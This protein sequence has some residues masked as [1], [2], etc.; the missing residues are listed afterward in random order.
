MHARAVGLL[1]SSS[2]QRGSLEVAS[3]CTGRPADG[4]G[5]GGSFKL[6]LREHALAV[7]A[8]RRGTPEGSSCSCGRM[9]C[10]CLHEIAHRLPTS[11][12]SLCAPWWACVQR[13]RR[14]EEEGRP[15]ECNGSSRG[16][17]HLDVDSALVK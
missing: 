14:K 2:G 6:Q 5:P 8:A 4:P 9:E 15:L 7:L 10:Q 16:G 3:Q 11:E 1:S 12:L 13:L 17:G